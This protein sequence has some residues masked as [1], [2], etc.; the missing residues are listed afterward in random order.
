MLCSYWSF[1]RPLPRAF[2]PWVVSLGLLLVTISS[3]SAEPAVGR[4]PL[5]DWPWAQRAGAIIHVDNDLLGRDNRDR[6]YTGGFS[7]SLPLADPQ[8]WKPAPW[9]DKLSSPQ[10]RGRVLAALQMKVMAFS[11]ENLADETPQSDDRPYASLW[12]TTAARQQVAADGTG[13]SFAAITVGVLGLRT[14]ETL[15]R[16]LHRISEVEL[17][18]GYDHQISAGGE[19]TTQLALAR[20]NLVAGGDI[21]AGADV[22]WSA[23]GRVGYVTEA[24]ISLAARAG[25]RATPWW[26]TVSELGDYASAPSF[27]IGAVGRERVV[28]AGVTLRVRAYNAFLQ[29][30]FR[31]S[32]VTVPRSRIEP[33]VATAWL[34]VGIATGK[35]SQFSYRLTAQSAEVEYGSA[36]RTHIWGSISWT[37]SF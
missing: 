33:L 35:G 20:R 12:A 36:A 14:T 5:A 22:W 32:N 29:G 24:A 6:D 2:A 21:G 7:V 18:E 16:A 19:P 27:G 10:D 28:E 3:A 37:R 11:P 13:A 17:P 23:S 34:G 25:H 26:A 30:Q 8:G 31:S 1:S 9:L 4:V 15:H